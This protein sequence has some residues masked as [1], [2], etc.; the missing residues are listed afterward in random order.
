MAL[1]SRKTG[2]IS[3]SVLVDASFI[4]SSV[5]CYTGLVHHIKFPGEHHQV[6]NL[7]R[8]II[9]GGQD[10]IVNVLGI[11][12]GVAAANGSTHILLAAA[13]ASAFAESIS[14]GAVAYTSSLAERDHYTKEMDRERVETETV[15]DQETQ[16]IRDIYA[17]K[18]FSGE[19][20]NQIV[21]KITSDRTT[22]VNI[23]MEEELHLSPVDTK[24]ILSTSVVVGVAAMV[25]SIIPV[26]P[27]FILAR[28]TAMPLTLIVSAVA[29]F[30]VGAYE[31]KV[32]V[33]VWWKNGLRLAIIG[34]TAALAGFVIGKFFQAP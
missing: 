5:T 7:W 30:T 34:M 16:E 21:A 18:G 26:F 27:F 4:A 23:M 33:G 32:Y 1:G 13:L 10:G 24:A 3:A 31:A 22:W 17:A 14:M 28:T 12:L 19:L 25:G 2:R 11:V 8:D 15:P 29:L 20:L 9:L 6:G